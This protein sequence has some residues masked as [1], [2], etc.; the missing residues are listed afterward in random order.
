M[1]R[2]F[3][4]LIEFERWNWYAKNS[5]AVFVVA[6]I[7]SMACALLFFTFTHI[8]QYIVLVMVALS[9]F[10]VYVPRLL[11][12]GVR[13]LPVAKALSVALAWTLASVGL[14][15]F[16][17]TET[18]LSA[19]IYGA[20]LFFFIF[21][22]TQPF[23]IRDMEV[24]KSTNTNTLPIM[25]GVSNTKIVCILSLFLSFVFALMIE[26]KAYC[27][28]AVFS[29]IYAAFFILNANQSKSEYYYS[30]F[31]ESTLMARFLFFYVTKGFF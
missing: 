15:Y 24:D 5:K 10:Y 20:E 14:P 30:F 16:S 22:V 23:D 31:L 7:A 8:V 18:N 6:L 3:P 2:K 13:S 28:G 17:A 27:M 11:P 29:A 4:S 12:K 25:I 21:S 19:T 9:V 26:H 1:L